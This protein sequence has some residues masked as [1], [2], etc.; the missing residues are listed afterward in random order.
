MSDNSLIIK[1]CIDDMHRAAIREKGYLFVPGYFDHDSM[2]LLEREYTLLLKQ[3]KKILRESQLLG[4]DLRQY[5]HL[6]QEAL[7]VVPEANKPLEV[8]RFERISQWSAAVNEHFVKKL[9]LLIND[10]TGAPFVLFKDKCNVKNPGGGA[11]PP[12]QDI[13]AYNHFNSDFYLSAAVILDDSTLQNGCLQVADDY[14]S[15]SNTAS[16][17]IET[18]FGSHPFFDF[19]KGGGNNGDIKQSISERFNWKPIEARRG[20][21]ILFDAFVPHYS[22][23][24]HSAGSRRNFFFTFNPL[25]AGRNYQRYYE[26]KVKDFDNPMFHVSTPTSHK[27]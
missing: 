21:V 3:S 12:H 18:Q 5:Y 27:T 6:N 24:N 20:D 15:V 16:K 14:K 23:P 19:Y 26:S 8:C 4:C 13:A 2:A 10:L 9:Q 1:P 11:F 25:S 7:I 22:E 17:I